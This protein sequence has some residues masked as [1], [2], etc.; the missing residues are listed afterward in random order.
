MIRELLSNILS[1]RDIDSHYIFIILGL[2]IRI[3]HS[4][5][6]PEIILKESGVTQ[7]KRAVPVIVSL[8]SFPGRIH[9][10]SKGIRTLLN[11][12]VKPD[13]IVLWLTAE[14]FPER[15]KN[16]PADLVELQKYGLTIEWCEEN[17][18]S[19]TK[20]IPS[21]KKYPNAVIIT[22]DDDIYYAKDTVE[23]LYKS[24]L[25]NPNTIHTHR[26]A[27]ITVRDG[28]I[29]N[30]PSRILYTKTYSEP[31]FL[32]RLSGYAGT[33]YPPGC[34]SEEIFNKEFFLN[35]IKTHDDIWF[36]AAAILKGTKIQTVK[37]YRESVYTVNDSQDVALCKLN[38]VTTT[39]KAYEILLKHYPQILNIIEEARG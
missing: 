28:K 22:V 35:H 39:E 16:L 32:N 26:S 5:R 1:I 10:V 24:Y 34:L 33:L 12:T 25:R 23:T 2:Q 6:E 17:L 27:R 19:F 29:Y 37:G 3:K 14:Q 20:L 38:R 15:E 9:T 36:W 4:H 30:V 21:L 13:M 11:Q 8:T 18:R 7:E 31:S